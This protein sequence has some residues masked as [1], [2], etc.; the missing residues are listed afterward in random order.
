MVYLEVS[1]ARKN[2]AKRFG[3][4]WDLRE[5]LWYFP[6][7]VLP[8]ELERFRPAREGNGPLAKII[9][10]IPF[11]DRDIAAKAGARWDSENKVYFFEKRPGQDLPIEL[12]GFEPKEFSWEEKIQREL[13]GRIVR[14]RSGAEKDH[15]QTSPARGCHGDLQRLQ[16]AGIRAFFWPMMLGSERPSRHGPVSS[17]SSKTRR[18]NGRY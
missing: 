18:R 4:R 10:D 2:E 17:R 12:D 8:K 13:N 11:A 9:L 14:E 6:G 3:V 1:Y 15:A 7:E 16:R 5:K